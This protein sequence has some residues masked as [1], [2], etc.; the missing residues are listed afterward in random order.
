[1][2]NAAGDPN[3]YE[4]G[5][6]M[7]DPDAELDDWF[8]RF[9]CDSSGQVIRFWAYQ[10][11]THGGKDWSAFD[12]VMRLANRHG[13]KVIPVLE[14]QWVECSEGGYK[15]N[16]WYSDGYLKPYGTNS[17]SYKEYVR[18][19]VERYKDEPAIA[20]WM[21][22]NE[23]ESK[24]TSGEEDPEALYSFARD[25]STFI[26]R[27]DQ[28]HLITLGSI[29]CR[30]PGVSGPNYQ[31]LYGLP[32]ID[33]LEFHDYGADDKAMP[34]AL[35]SAINTSNQLNKPILIGEAGITTCGSYNGSKQEIQQSRAQ[36]FD[37]KIGAF[38]DKGGA[39]YLIWAWHPNS[40]CS[41]DFTTGDP[42]NAVLISHS[43]G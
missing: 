27:L 4:C 26:K 30:Q 28:N 36:R 21:L 11:Y 17:L 33:F 24:K 18:C 2:Y 37:A 35:A 31:R 6:W 43:S 40:N 12:R 5:P 7:Q 9:K 1:M 10:S 34:A 42:L 8:N 15:Y 23:A 41:Y 14:N 16:T 3:I 39:G 20:A 25:M 13:L 22:M 19:V 29:G 32:T 38:F